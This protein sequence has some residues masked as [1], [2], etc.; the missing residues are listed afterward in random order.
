MR[1]SL[2]APE[3]PVDW[4][5]LLN[6]YHRRKVSYRE[7]MMAVDFLNPYVFVW[8]ETEKMP[9]P[10]P[11]VDPN[12]LE[13]WN[14]AKDKAK[15]EFA[16]IIKFEKTL[17]FK[18]G[19][20]V[21]AETLMRFAPPSVSMNTL[22]AAF[23]VSQDDAH[24]AE[25]NFN[26]FMSKRIYNMYHNMTK[27]VWTDTQMEPLRRSAPMSGDHISGRIDPRTG[28]RNRPRWG[29]GEKAGMRIRWDAAHNYMKP[30]VIEGKW[31]DLDDDDKVAVQIAHNM[32]GK[33]DE[34]AGHKKDDRSHK[35]VIHT[36][37]RP[38]Q[39]R[40]FLQGIYQYISHHENAAGDSASRFGPAARARALTRA[41]QKVA[42][43]EEERRKIVSGE[44]K[45]FKLTDRYKPHKVQPGTIAAKNIA[46]GNRGHHMGNEID[47][48]S[49]QLVPLQG[50]HGPTAYDQHENE[51]E[52][53]KVPRSSPGQSGRQSVA[54][55]NSAGGISL[56]ELYDAVQH[57]GMKRLQPEYRGVRARQSKRLNADLKPV[58]LDEWREWRSF[59]P[60]PGES[61]RDFEV[62]KREH[63]YNIRAGK[64][65]PSVW[66][67]ILDDIKNGFI[68]T[69]NG[70]IEFDARMR[71]QF[72]R[73]AARIAVDNSVISREEEWPSL[74]WTVRS[75]Y[76]LKVIQQLHKN[77]HPEI[78]GTAE[79]RDHASGRQGSAQ[80]R[81]RM[82]DR[83]KERDYRA[84][85]QAMADRQR[86]N[87]AA[88][89]RP[90]RPERPETPEAGE[91][92]RLEIGSASP[93]TTRE[94]AIAKIARID[95][96]VSRLSSIATSG[97][98]ARPVADLKP[99]A[100]RLH[101]EGLNV[102]KVI[103]KHG[104]DSNRYSRA[105]ERFFS[106]VQE[107]RREFGPQY[108]E[109]VSRIRER[110]RKI[111][112]LG[113]SRRDAEPLALSLRRLRS[114]LAKAML[115]DVI[116]KSKEG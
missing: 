14:A 58:S 19:R 11:T 107:A 24:D 93:P 49:K 68:E 2:D 72:N 83:Q 63:F 70:R 46:E 96:Q 17:G 98:K 54:H 28:K 34:L 36:W 116:R 64:P 51:V 100:D 67:G 86:R 30:V 43:V 85:M 88:K 48:D 66:R 13:T 29:I 22:A 50:Q 37:L 113:R 12:D 103:A 79:E 47:V 44:Y 74:D 6:D 26:L 52:R 115:A 39:E 69:K 101:K 42:K 112:R 94:K 60:L 10:N 92:K 16:H 97:A 110:S 35:W 7:H 18:P 53:Q 1:K 71:K 3:V 111:G 25:R 114:G 55:P 31:D 76:F 20:L 65:N 109:D 38:S 40:F 80:R 8:S 61:K 33:N 57:A 73:A 90:Q 99:L 32:L 105:W 27:S 9:M 108:W 41:K 75:K 87:K 59:K 4:E 62:R 23:G 56:P 82:A 5:S 104:V 89:I 45:P 102:R 81:I 21:T 91:K 106:V 15:D 95:G 84:K 78:Y 77:A